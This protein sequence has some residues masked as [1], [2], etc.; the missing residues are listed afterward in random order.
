M[1]AQLISAL[2][3][4]V[5]TP[6]LAQWTTR[7]SGTTTEFRGLHAV[8]ARVVWAAGRGGVVARTSDGGVTWRADSIPGAAGLFLI[9]VR[10]RDANTAWVLGTAF[11]GAPMAR[12]YRTG[13]GGR[14]WQLQYE[15]TTTGIF[16]DGL[17]FWDARHGIA[18]SDPIDGRFFIVT[19]E[20]GGEHWV[21]V[22]PDRIPP[23]ASGEA[24]FAASGTAI[25][26]LGSRE[27][28][29]ATGGGPW[30]RVFHSRDRGATWNVFE[31]PAAGGT[32]KGIFGIAFRDP[33]HGVAV[34]GDYQ[35]RDESAMN[36]L[37]SDDGGG[38]WMV[39]TSPGLAGVQYG[40]VSAGGGAYIAAGPLSSARSADG[41]HTWTR[42]LGPGFNT[43]SCAARICWAAGT[44]GRIARLNR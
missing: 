19:T 28:W 18:F 24:A 40:V 27:V 2:G 11:G 32:A 38:T 17:A 37:L 31:T 1:R 10:A 5:A 25:T 33:R 20:D 43:V 41:G 4:A 15:N 21:R 42:L 16:F 36:L 7:A 26:T 8:S 13:D 35:K 6:A 39:A 14:S 44:E 29:I 22:A 30:A 3:F 23:A 12:I 9:A 34:G